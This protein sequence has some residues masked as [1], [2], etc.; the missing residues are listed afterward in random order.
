MDIVIL[1]YPGVRLMDVTA[2]LEV[3]GTAA[4]F[5]APYRVRL[6]S[7]AGGPVITSTG[8]SLLTEPPVTSA[9]T[10]VVPG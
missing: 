4:G 8:V 2:P 1:A 3:F 6:C 9:H 5:G 7:P 10:L